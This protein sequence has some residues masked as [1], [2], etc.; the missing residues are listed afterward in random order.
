[1]QLPSVYTVTCLRPVHHSKLVQHYS[2]SPDTKQCNC[3]HNEIIQYF[4]TIIMICSVA[5]DFALGH[6]MDSL[7]RTGVELIVR[8]KDK[9]SFILH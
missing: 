4:K 5:L 1:M 7:S 3:L 9:I 6:G 2:D 8:V